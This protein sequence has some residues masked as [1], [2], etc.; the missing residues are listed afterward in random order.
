MSVNNNIRVVTGN[1][2][3]VDK[4]ALENPN[5]KIDLIDFNRSSFNPFKNLRYLFS[6]SQKISEYR[7]KKIIFVSNKLILLGTLLNLFRLK[8]TAQYFFFFSGLGYLFISQSF[9][10]KS[11]K[12][13]LLNS[14][15]LSSLRRNIELVVQNNDDLLFFTKKLNLTHVP[16]HL[17]K[18]NGIQSQT[19]LPKKMDVINILFAGRLLRDKG[20]FEYLD[21]AKYIK[22]CYPAKHINFFLAGDCDFANPNCIS[23]EELELIKLNQNIQFFGKLAYDELCQL[24]CK[25]HIFIL[26]SYREGLPRVALEAG[27]FGLALLLSN[28]PGCRECLQNDFNGYLFTLSNEMDLIT[29][30]EYFITH[31]DELKRMCDN[32][33]TFIENNFS[34]DIIF[35]KFREVLS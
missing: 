8:G 18:G 4:S 1:F 33:P 12:F 35:S 30:I 23:R 10:A 32:S 11:L 2:S 7:P 25:S 13:L 5:L 16:I 29:K 9:A 15:K 21:A 19:F 26:P 20:I 3:S 6:L 31:P 28:V 22:K 34:E 24:Y 14:I 17:I 27:S